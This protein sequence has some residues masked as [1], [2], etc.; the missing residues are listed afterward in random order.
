MRVLVADDDGVH[1]QSLS[2][3]LK[4]KASDVVTAFDAM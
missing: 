1:V 4:A 2:S 3:R